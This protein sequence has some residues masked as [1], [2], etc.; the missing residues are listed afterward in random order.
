MISHIV[1][2]TVGT[3]FAALVENQILPA[4]LRCGETLSSIYR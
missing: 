2:G 4:R 3:K 1:C